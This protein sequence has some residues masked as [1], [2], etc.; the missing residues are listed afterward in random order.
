[1]APPR[2]VARTP[3]PAVSVALSLLIAL[4]LALGQASPPAVTT[5]YATVV[6]ARTGER[7]PELMAQNTTLEIT[8]YGANQ[9]FNMVGRPWLLFASL[10]QKGVLLP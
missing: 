6:V 9:M 5:V 3:A 8:S 4:P 7:N 2:R 1:M 10:T